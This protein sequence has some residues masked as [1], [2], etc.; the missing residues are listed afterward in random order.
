MNFGGSVPKW[1]GRFAYLVGLFDIAAN[2]FRP[3]RIRAHKIDHFIPLAV[4][5]TAFATAFSPE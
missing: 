3:I 4:H 5:S 2:T 1:I